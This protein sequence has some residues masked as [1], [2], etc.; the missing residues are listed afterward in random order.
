MNRRIEMNDRRCRS[1]RPR[2][3]RAATVSVEPLESRRLF[4]AS[5]P[6]A[7]IAA[8]PSVNRDGPVVFVSASVA[9]SAP[10][11]SVGTV[12]QAMAGPYVKSTTV[13]A[14]LAARNN[15]TRPSTE[16]IFVRQDLFG[17]WTGTFLS[18]KNPTSTPL[19]LSVDFYRRQAVTRLSLTQAFT[20]AFDLSAMTGESRALTTVTMSHQVDVRIAI[21]TPTATT[22]FS[23]AVSLNGKVISGRYAVLMNGRYEVGS[24]TLTKQVAA[25]TI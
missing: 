23:G 15:P 11:A 9:P 7:A 18:A 5:V 3:T 2:A 16:P 10:A 17:L 25:P 21:M 20:G 1:N 12:P 24:F 13:I 14:A 22:S 19:A 4:D 8:G 6:L